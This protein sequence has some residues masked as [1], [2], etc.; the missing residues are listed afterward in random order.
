M[1]N[2][3]SVVYPIDDD[4]AVNVDS[5]V[6]PFVARFV[7]ELAQKNRVGGVFHADAAGKEPQ[8]AVADKIVVDV[9]SG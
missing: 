8:L 6:F 7:D 5:F 4:G 9:G 2:A 3:V 1:Q